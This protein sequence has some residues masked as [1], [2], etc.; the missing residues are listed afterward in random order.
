[1][2]VTAANVRPLAGAITRKGRA[3]GNLTMGMPFYPASDGDWE[4]ADANVTA[5]I[6]AGRGIIVE[7][8]FKAPGGTTAVDGD[9]VT[10]VVFGP[11]GGFSSLTPGALQY[12][13]ATVG[14]LT[15]TAPTGATNWQHAI[16]YAL[17]ANTVFVMPGISAPISSS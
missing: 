13:S 5:A 7:V 10:G 14:T 9:E 12:I 1:M 2:A 16:G 6:A 11:V 4:A 3:G 8:P 15:E 17:D